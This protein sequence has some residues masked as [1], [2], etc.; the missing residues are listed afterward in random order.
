MGMTVPRTSPPGDDFVALMLPLESV[1]MAG[2]LDGRLHRLRA[3]ADEGEIADLSRGDLF[4]NLGQL[5]GGE[6][7]KLHGSEIG[8]LTDL[9][10]DRLGDLLAAVSHMDRPGHPRDQVEISLPLLVG[11]MDPFSLGHDGDPFPDLVFGGALQNE[12]L[13]VHL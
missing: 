10:I 2:Q 7:G 5:D 8:H 9:V 13:Q 3:V 12:G 4:Q 11:H 6:I 1:I